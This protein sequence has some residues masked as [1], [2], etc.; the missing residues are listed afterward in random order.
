M[1]NSVVIVRLNLG[2]VLDETVMTH[3]DVNELLEVM[4]LNSFDITP[5]Y[6]LLTDIDTGKVVKAQDLQSGVVV[7]ESHAE[8]PQ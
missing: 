6:H 7:S 3:E 4:D 8:I 1:K 5:T 2:P